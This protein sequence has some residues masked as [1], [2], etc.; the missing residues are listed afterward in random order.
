MGVKTLFSNGPHQCLGQSILGQGYC[1]LVVLAQQSDRHVALKIRRTDAPVPNLHNEAKCLAIA[2]QLEIGPTLWGHSQNFLVM[3]YLT[4]PTILE[5]LQANQTILTA[6]QVRLVLHNLMEQ[7]FRLDQ[8]GLDHGNLRCVTEHAIIRGNR[9]ILIDFS[10]SSLNRRSANVTT[11]TQGLFWG[12]Y[13]ATLMTPF[14][15]LPSKD[16]LIPI[17]QAYKQK[18]S[19]DRFDTLLQRIGLLG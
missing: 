7:C 12:T 15:S 2:N 16:N 11:L 13:L 17:L 6:Q 19:R 1:G 14:M 5:W 18:P 10:S 8:Q 9:P 4:G 3:E